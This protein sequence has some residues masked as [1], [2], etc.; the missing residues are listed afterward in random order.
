ME[1]IKEIKAKKYKIGNTRFVDETTI[2]KLAFEELKN[3]EKHRKLGC[4]Y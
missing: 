4:T 1:C 3:R 2:N